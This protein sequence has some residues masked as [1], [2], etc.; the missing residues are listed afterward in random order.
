MEKCRGSSTN[1]PLH[2]PILL[3]S[4]LHAGEW[5]ASRPFSITL[6]E[7]SPNIQRIGERLGPEPVWKL[8]KRDKNLAPVGNRTTNLRT[9]IPTQVAKLTTHCAFQGFRASVFTYPYTQ[10]NN[11]SC[12]YSAKHGVPLWI[13]KRVCRIVNVANSK[14]TPQ[15]HNNFA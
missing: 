7:G 14:K 13:N 6:G 1:Y 12:V 11:S 9:S 10:T 4:T 2:F 15:P 5:S 3:T 8:W